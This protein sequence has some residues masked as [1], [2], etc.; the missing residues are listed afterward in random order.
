M[1][2]TQFSGMKYQTAVSKNQ[3]Q[4]TIYP[5]YSLYTRKSYFILQR[6]TLFSRPFVV[7]IILYEKEYQNKKD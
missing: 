2:E 4:K 7:E 6:I 5:K 1:L 3:T